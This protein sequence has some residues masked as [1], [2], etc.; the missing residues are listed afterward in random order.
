MSSVMLLPVP[1]ATSS[2][3]A[4]KSTTTS[5]RRDAWFTCSSRFCAV[6]SRSLRPTKPML[7]A[8]ALSAVHLRVGSVADVIS[9]RPKSMSSSCRPIASPVPP[10]T[11]T[12]TSMPLPPIVSTL[13]EICCAGVGPRAARVS[14]RVDFSKAR[15]PLNWTKPN[16]SISRKPLARSVSPSAPSISRSRL[17]PAPVR[18][19]S[20]VAPSL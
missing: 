17:V 8:S 5:F 10:L 6:G 19:L 12:N 9:A 7:L 4:A 18:T 20:S 1:V 11:P 2:D 15:L 14:W 13:A 3:W 16:R